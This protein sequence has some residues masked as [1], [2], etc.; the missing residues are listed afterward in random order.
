M[1]LLVVEN[2]V[3]TIIYSEFKYVLSGLPHSKNISI[4][5]DW[6]EQG[7]HSYSMLDAPNRGQ[8]YQ[9]RCTHSTSQ[10]SKLAAV[11]HQLS[12]SHWD[13]AVIFLGQVKFLHSKQN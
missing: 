6:N 12:V 2:S 7:Q 10:I 8:V 1:T 5:A 11:P 4:I 13:I 9:T 3:Q